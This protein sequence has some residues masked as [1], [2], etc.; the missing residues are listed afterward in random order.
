VVIFPV[1]YHMG[2]P[3]D[4][5]IQRQ[6]MKRGIEAFGEDYGGWNDSGTPGNL[7]Y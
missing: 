1:G 2:N 5:E 6:I 4:R 7:S 3:S